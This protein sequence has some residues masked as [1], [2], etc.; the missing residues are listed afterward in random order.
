MIQKRKRQIFLALACSVALGVLLFVL[1]STV[2]K[3]VETERAEGVFI[4]P[5]LALE[6]IAEISVTNELGSYRLYR[7]E[8]GQLYFEGAEYVLYNQNMIAYLRS[9]VAYLSVS[10]EVEEPVGAEE[11]G[12]TDERASAS[13]T[14]TPLEGE[15]YRVLIGDELVGGQGYYAAL[16][17]DARVFVLDSSLSRL[18]ASN[19]QFYLSGQV[20]VSLSEEDYYTIDTFSIKKLGKP[21]V[22]VEMIPED[23]KKDSDLSTHRVVYPAP[24]E[25]NVDLL[26]R[27]FKS[28]ISFVGRDVCEYGLSGYDE[29]RFAETMKQYALVSETDAAMYCEVSYD[30]HGQTTTLYFSRPDTEAGVTYV[31]SPGFDVICAFSSGDLAWAEYDLMEFTQEEIFARSIGDVLSIGVEADGLSASFVLTHGEAAE[32][33][34]VKHGNQRIDTQNFRRFYN[35]ILYT[36]NYGY[37]TVPEDYESRHAMTMTVTLTDGTKYVYDFFD[38]TSLYSYYQIGGEG[39]FCVKRDY[40]QKLAA[41]A[42]R[43]ISGQS[44]EAVQYN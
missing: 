43:L 22:T 24:Y 35:Q 30:Y 31:Y 17:G 32:D 41:D 18:L 13:F 14:V 1:F 40:V 38:T 3:P 44:V 2:W 16:E 15:P 19:V 4:V 36:E 26:T 6:E 33:L 27:L 5:P 10:G 20:A 42:A 25:P 21:F 9:C 8:D 12:L 11:Y 37:A 7:A 39:V 23:E 28:F 34:V 29:A